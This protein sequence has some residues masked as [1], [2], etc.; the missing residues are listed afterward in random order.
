MMDDFKDFKLIVISI[1]AHAEIQTGV[2]AHVVIHRNINAQQT[3]IA[4][5]PQPVRQ[6]T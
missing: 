5:E 4:K 2:P 6:T 3:L 1:N